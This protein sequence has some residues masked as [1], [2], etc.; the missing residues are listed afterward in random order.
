MRVLLINPPQK[1]FYGSGTFKLYFPIGLLGI[2]SNIKDICNVKIFDCL[3]ERPEIKKNKDY[4]LYGSSYENIEDEIRKF[5]PKILGISIPFSAQSETAKLL[6]K[7]CR[8]IDQNIIIVLGG[9]DPSV[10]YKEFLEGGFCDFCVVGEGEKTFY[11][12]IKKFN[13]KN[14]PKNIDGLA[15]K[16]KNKIYFKA[17]EPIKN[18]DILPYPAYDLIDFKKYIKNPHLYKNRGAISKNSI[19]IITSRGCPFDCVFCSIDLHMGKKYRVHSPDYIINHI[20]FLILKYNIKNFH[21]EDDNIS[22]DKKRFELIL[23]KII[24]NKLK[25]RW[26]VPNGVRVDTL[27]FNLI[28]KIKK[29]GCIH[30][31]IGIESG[32]QRVL[33]KIIKKNLSL[34]KTL[35]IVEYCKKIKLPLSAFYVIGFPGE[36]LEEIKQ[37]IKLAIRLLKEYEVHPVLFFATPLY[38]TRLYNQCLEKGIIKKDLSDKDLSIATQRYGLPL[39]ATSEFSKQDLIDTIKEFNQKLREEKKILRRKKIFFL[40]KHPYESFVK[41]FNQPNL[42]RKVLFR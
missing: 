19:S 31:S 14:F 30:I 9:P 32:N 33:N 41:I 24:E 2:A 13:S 8:K 18:L 1:Y 25:I 20:K 3:V 17:R 40:I 23:D 4:I 21:F 27:D 12:F 7:I 16:I 6:V 37:T 11:E 10:R 15:Y 38:G 28:K 22:L 35:K 42:I 39:I 26:D 29:A 34:K 5:R 36:K